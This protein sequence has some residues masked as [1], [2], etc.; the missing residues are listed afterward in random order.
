MA[1]YITDEVKEEIKSL[2]ITAV[3]ELIGAVPKRKKFLCYNG[4]DTEPSLNVSEKK[5]LY[6]CFG[7]GEGGYVIKLLMNARKIDYIAACHFLMAEYGIQP[8]QTQMS[9]PIKKTTN[10]SKLP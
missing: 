1:D 9:R 2:S 10:Q 8:G 5:G 6:Y 7:C 3:A 4:H